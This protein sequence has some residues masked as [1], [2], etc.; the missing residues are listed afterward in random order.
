MAKITVLYAPK[1]G[2]TPTKPKTAKRRLAEN[3]NE[4][5]SVAQQVRTKPK[6]G[7]RT[8]K[9]KANKAK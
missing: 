1:L 9:N 4:V 7:Q 6:R 8:A 2:S 3:P 5:S